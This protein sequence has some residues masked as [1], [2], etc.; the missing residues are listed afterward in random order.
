MSCAP[1]NFNKF[2][3][4]DYRDGNKFDLH[5]TTAVKRIII[6]ARSQGVFIINVSTYFIGFF[7]FLVYARSYGT[8]R[9]RFRARISLRGVGVE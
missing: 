4:V 1:G 7:L 2:R 6:V 9:K 8:T 5:K 3:D